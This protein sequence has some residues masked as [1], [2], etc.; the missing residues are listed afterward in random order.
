MSY[1]NIY[2]LHRADD[3]LNFYKSNQELIWLSDCQ[4]WICCNPKL[5]NL[6]LRNNNF[7]VINSAPRAIIDRLNIDIMFIQ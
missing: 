7:L 3:R 4:K 6:I 2:H 5:I 1:K